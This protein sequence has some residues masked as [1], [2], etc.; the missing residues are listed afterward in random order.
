MA[1][2]AFWLFYRRGLGSSHP[3]SGFGEGPFPPKHSEALSTTVKY[4]SV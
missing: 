2:T 3:L 4:V 1:E